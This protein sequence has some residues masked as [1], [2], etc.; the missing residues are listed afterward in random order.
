MP[1]KFEKARK[2]VYAHGALWER[3]LFSHLFEGAS[4]AHVHQCLT[5]YKN[6][7]GGWGHGLECDI[8]TPDS[9]P[10]ALEFALQIVRVTGIRANSLF[11]DA[12]EWLA[13]N[14]APDGAL[15]NPPSVLDY[16]CATHWKETSGQTIPASTVGNLMRQSAV[17]GDIEITTQS[18]V[19]DHLT[20]KRIQRNDRLIAAYHAHDYFMNVS[21]FPDL[22][23]YRAAVLENILSLTDAA[24]PHHYYQFAFFAPDPESPVSQAASPKLKRRIFSALA[25]MQQSDGA[26]H[27]EYSNPHWAVWTTIM[28][29]HV[30]RQHGYWQPDEF[31]EGIRDGGHASTRRSIA[32]T[33]APHAKSSLRGSAVNS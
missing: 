20:L 19:L 2:Y 15:L 26:W 21:D 11:H 30:L 10:L 9:H 24:E 28:V 33:G 29:L 23:L 17:L 32:R 27:D 22:P 8:K 3:V 7:D 13:R 1:V 14:R 16:P 5:C 31:N 12:P 18:W 4:L 25:K 6:P